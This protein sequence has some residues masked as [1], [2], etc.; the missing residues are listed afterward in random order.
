[1]KD[2]TASMAKQSSRQQ[3]GVL[4][5]SEN[6]AISQRHIIVLRCKRK[7]DECWAFERNLWGGKVAAEFLSKNVACQAATIVAGKISGCGYF[8]QRE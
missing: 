7:K 3:C 2:V 1:M 4:R 6:K 5:S 8:S